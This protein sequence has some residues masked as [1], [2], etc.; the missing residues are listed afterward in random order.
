MTTGTGENM[1]LKTI[2]HQEKINKAKNIAEMFEI[3]R[4]VV[5]NEVGRYQA[6]VMVGLADLGGFYAEQIGAL[7]NL[8]ANTILLNRNLLDKIKPQQYNFYLFYI[9]LHEYMHAVGYDEEDTR[10]L[11]R[12]IS[13]KLL[14]ETHMVTKMSANFDRFFPKMEYCKPKAH[15]EFVLGVDKKNTNY[16]N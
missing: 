7:Y 16:I 8:D 4:E 9:L 2:V 11:V 13:K 10:Y 5:D 14:G 1:K 15:I 3:V 6:G 12:G